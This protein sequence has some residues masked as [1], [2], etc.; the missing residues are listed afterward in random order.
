M[1]FA[2]LALVLLTGC[3]ATPAA[4]APSTAAPTASDTAGAVTPFPAGFDVEGHRGARRLAPENTLP[5]FETALDLG[6]TTLE[7]DLHLSADGEL[8]IWH[9]DTVPAEKCRLDPMAATPFRPIP[10]MRPRR[11][12]R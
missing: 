5:A 8:V 11:R 4:V 10:T 7:L 3:V 2:T 9:D 12:R 1:L 6:V